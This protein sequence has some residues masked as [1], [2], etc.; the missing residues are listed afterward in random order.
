[1]WALFDATSDYVK[2]SARK[3]DQFKKKHPKFSK[4]KTQAT[5]YAALARAAGKVPEQAV[6]VKQAMQVKKQKVKVK[7]QVGKVVEQ[8]EQSRSGRKR[9]RPLKFDE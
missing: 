1:M 6:K 2:G 8:L 5:R 9:K 3:I 7:K 4:G